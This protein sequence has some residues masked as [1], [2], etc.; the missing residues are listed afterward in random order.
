MNRRAGS[1]APRAHVY[2]TSR[3][4]A[5]AAWMT[6]T[7]TPGRT[8]GACPAPLHPA[9]RG[10]GRRRGRVRTGW[11]DI[12]D[13]TGRAQQ[14]GPPARHAGPV[15][16]ER[17]PPGRP[18]THRRTPAARSTPPRR[19]FGFTRPSRRVR[20]FLLLFSLFRVRETSFW[21]GWR[22]LR[23]SWSA[24]SSIAYIL[25]DGHAGTGLVDWA[26]LTCGDPLYD[27]AT[28]HFWTRRIRLPDPHTA[29]G[30]AGPR[31]LGSVFCTTP[32]CQGGSPGCVSQHSRSR[33]GDGRGQCGP[34][35]ASR[36]RRGE[37]RCGMARATT[38]ARHAWQVRPKV[39]LAR[40]PNVP[41]IKTGSRRV[42]AFQ[43]RGE[44]GAHCPTRR[45]WS[46]EAFTT[47]SRGLL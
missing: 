22:G 45:A 14:P 8:G 40:G 12:A 33:P 17:A 9:L 13:P 23:P 18:A 46:R 43:G 11:R 6:L 31:T 39:G 35:N 21:D 2:S 25:S 42:D 37:N 5:F 41:Q 3:Q 29:P 47:L 10:H 24:T 15:G 19:G 16:G 26:N 34:V 32:F 36:A 28:F 7:S 20:G 4:M 30:S 44:H 27:L 38:H 1:W